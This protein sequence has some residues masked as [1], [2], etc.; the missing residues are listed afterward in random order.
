VTYVAAQEVPIAPLLDQLEFVENRSRWG[1]KFRFGLFE[2]S[3]H[4]ML[5]IARSMS[6]DLDALHFNM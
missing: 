2:V 4:D 1:Y 6:A 5:L 3:N